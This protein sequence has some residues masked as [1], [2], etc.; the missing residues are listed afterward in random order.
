MV[1]GRRA[2]VEAGREE[3]EE[4]RARLGGDAAVLCSWLNVEPVRLRGEQSMRCAASPLN[5]LVATG[6][7]LRHSAFWDFCVV[8]TNDQR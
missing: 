1:A 2:A 5:H 6:I 7:A 3:V 4:E 8:T